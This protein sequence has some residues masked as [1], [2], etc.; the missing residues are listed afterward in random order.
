MLRDFALA[1]RLEEYWFEDKVDK[2]MSA[3]RLLNYPDLEE[4]EKPLKGQ[5]RAG[6]HTDYGALTI[7]RS[8][9]PGLQVKK[10]GE[11]SE[12]VDVPLL[13][14]AFIV[15][16]GDLMQRWTNDRWKST[17][18]RVI[19]PPKDGRK[20]P[21]QSIAFFV[22]INGDAEVLPIETCV[23]ESDPARYNSIL[24]KDHLMQKHLA[25]MGITEE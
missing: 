1:L 14:N 21:R 16:L 20:H 22:N 3:L 7:L 6:A 17:L 4:K 18:H 25:S 15:N 8:G 2:H 13:E 23:N 9:G 5:L 10:D 11:V 24:A 19:L 12:W